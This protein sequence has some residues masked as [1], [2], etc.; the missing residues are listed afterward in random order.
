MEKIGI[1]G[2]FPHAWGP[3]QLD[4]IKGGTRG[5]QTQ[6]KISSFMQSLNQECLKILLL[7]HE[8]ILLLESMFVNYLCAKLNSHLGT[9][10]SSLYVQISII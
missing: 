1:G 5:S 7:L 8:S 10:G 4:S 2:A 9:P 6:K 3:T